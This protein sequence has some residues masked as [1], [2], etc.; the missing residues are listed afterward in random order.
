[1]KVKRNASK[2]RTE[3][4]PV[5]MTRNEYRKALLNEGYP[6]PFIEKTTIPELLLR[7]SSELFIKGDLD[8]KIA[9][10]TRR[11]LTQLSNLGWTDD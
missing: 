8:S 2:A 5:D 6:K 1:M 4:K 3:P 11:R 7:I 9:K 10:E